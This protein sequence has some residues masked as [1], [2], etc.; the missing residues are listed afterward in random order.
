MTITTEHALDVLAKAD[1]L[2]TAADVDA[3]LDKM[4]VD[5]SE[6]LSKSD[7]LVISVMTGGLI[8]AG[9]LIPRLD[10]PMQMDYLHATRYLGNTSGGDLRWIV[11]PVASLQDRTVLLIDDIFDEGLTLTAIIEYCKDN[12]AKEVLSAVLIN[13]VHQR[14]TTVVPD[15][16]GLD[17][18]DRYV[19]GYGMDYK[20]YLRNVCG[21]YAVKEDG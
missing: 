10:F 9:M 15:F 8:P 19:F 4:A 18:E 17:V 16:I 21:I 3:A 5:I 12:G 2:F 1:R 14:K 11:E 6:R 7:P 13:K 20:G